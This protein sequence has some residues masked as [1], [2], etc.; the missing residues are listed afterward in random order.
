MSVLRTLE[1]IWSYLSKVT[2]V[3]ISC[4]QLPLQASLDDPQSF[5]S[6]IISDSLRIS[7][8]FC[9][10]QRGLWMISMTS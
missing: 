3:N 7:H 1:I 2:A 8:V 10:Y 4:L 9:V 5:L 6:T